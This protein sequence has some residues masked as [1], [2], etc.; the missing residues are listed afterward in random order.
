[1]SVNVITAAP[2]LQLVSVP[3]TA[4]R[5]GPFTNVAGSLEGYPVWT[6]PTTANV[7]VRVSLYVGCAT[8]DVAPQSVTIHADAVDPFGNLGSVATTVLAPTAQS[9]AT[10]VMWVAAGSSVK[11]Y[12]DG[13]KASH[14]S[15]AAVVEEL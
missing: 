2:A 10:G 11:L 5:F 3:Q 1:M 9:G 8:D 7:L 14:Y 4:V 15:Y 12:I 6:A 13:V